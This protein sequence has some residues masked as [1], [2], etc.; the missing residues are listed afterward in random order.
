MTEDELKRLKELPVP[1]PAAGAR[2][3]AVAAALAAFEPALSPDIGAPQ[4]SAALPR[5]RDTSSISEGSSKMRYRRPAAIAASIVALAVAVPLFMTHLVRTPTGPDRVAPH[6][7]L[8]AL[9]DPGAAHPP[10]PPPPADMERTASAASTP[11][12]P[13]VD[14][15]PEEKSTACPPQTLCMR[16]TG[17]VEQIK[18]KAA[19]VLAK[20]KAPAAA[21]DAPTARGV[22]TPPATS[23]D[24]IAPSGAIPADQGEACPPGRTCTRLPDEDARSLVF[25]D[26]LLFDINKL[27]G[28]DRYEPGTR[29]SMAQEYKR[30]EERQ[31]AELQ[32]KT[33]PASPATS[34]APPVKRQSGF[35]VPSYDFTFRPTYYAERGVLWGG[36]FRHRLET[37][38]YSIDIADIDDE[39]NPNAAVDSRLG[40]WRG[41][42]R[43]KGQ[44]NLDA[45][46]KYGWDITLESG[47]GQA[48]YDTSADQ[49]I[50][51]VNA[52]KFQRDECFV[53]TQSYIDT[54]V[55]N[56]ALDLREDRSLMLRYE[57]KRSC[58]YG[59]GT[60]ALSQVFYDIH[61][62]NAPTSGGHVATS[63]GIPTERVGACPPGKACTDHTRLMVAADWQRKVVDPID[64]VWTPF[65]DVR[66]DVYS[67]SD[68]TSA[69]PAPPTTSAQDYG[70][71]LPDVFK[72]TVP[73]NGASPSSKN[74]MFGP[75]PKIDRAQPLYLQTD[76]L[77]Y[78]E[79]NNRV[80][81]EGN[82]EI[83]YNNY[84]LAADKVIYDP[85][86]NKLTAEGNAQLK[87][88]N[89][90]I[91][92]ADRFEAT[93]DFRDA[94]IQALSV[95]TQDDTRVASRTAIRKESN[96]TELQNGK[97]T[98]CRNEPG[99][100]PLWCIRANRIIRDQQA[101]GRTT[102]TAD[103]DR[104]G[105]AAPHVAAR[106]SAPTVIAL[107]PTQTVV[108]NAPSTSSRPPAAAPPAPEQRVQACP[109]G[110][111]CTLL[112]PKS[113]ALEQAAAPSKPQ[114][115]PLENQVAAQAIRGFTVGGFRA[116]E[117]EPAQGLRFG[118][119]TPFP[120]DGRLDTL[121]SYFGD[122]P[123]PT[124]DGRDR[125][126]SAAANPVKS[127]ASEPVST[128]SIDVDSASYSFVR[129]ALNAA[130]LPPKEA[131]RVEE[132][133]N[134]FPYDYP[135][136]EDRSAPFRP[137]V[138]V[139]PSPWNPT[140]K[141][142]HIAIKG[143]DVP[144][145]ERPRAN[146]VLLID[147]SGSMAPEDRLP[148]IKNA[149]RM[150]IDTLRPDDTVGIVTYAGQTQVALEPTK[151]A[152]KRKILDVIE[153]LH[154]GGSTAGGAGIQEAYRM[155]EGAFDKTAVNRVVLATDGDFNV[156]TT[157]VDELKS[158]VERKRETGVYLSVL[159]V[160][161]G[162]YN[163]ALM[164]A[165]AQNGN[166]V[167][168]YID[169]LNEARKV[170]VEEA[171]SSLFPIAKDVK[172]QIEL[173]PG[174]VTEYRLIG[175][176]TRLLRREDFNNDKIDAGDIGS[177]HMVTAIYE[178]TPV[179]SPKL[180]EDLRYRQPVAA[181]PKDD[182][183]EYGFLRIN[184]KL[185]AESVSR[186]I[187]LP[188]TQALEK[189]AIDQ[190]PAD[191]RFS[192]A[193]AAFGQL[194]KGEPYL[195]GFG[196]D[197]VI[198]LAAPAR[199]EDLF[200]YRAEL[201][202]LVRLAKTAQP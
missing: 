128:F 179:G 119:S 39:L 167:A 140:N 187:E 125:F 101:A 53:L 28:Y 99:Q 137:T 51:D 164:Q 9:P 10:A 162:N 23:G 141:L 157:S 186:R 127:V 25:D 171:S 72:N 19:E 17:Q 195:K 74:S 200:G 199:G 20:R 55:E 161:R 124:Q 26:T 114:A 15:A 148:L 48:P 182:K 47:N 50:Q 178:V 40:N 54:F 147:T 151:V 175:Y 1:A 86:L 123:P 91:T 75:K 70:V 121:N 5:L 69:P 49:R 59:Y 194:L 60:D 21:E 136:P 100:P 120:A 145:S 158:L 18:Q 43:A 65:A 154:A 193:V 12:A 92:R 38:R 196:Y 102:P 183:G 184:Y 98:P 7:K 79:K 135:L 138:T 94:F 191:V 190:A 14:T 63:G 13:S 71:R 143:Y 56:A 44:F 170:L 165:L 103:L 188:I 87:D 173:N 197:E 85:S 111:T 142:V 27:S 113:R 153:R 35:L 176:E 198:A 155:A 169:T 174:M 76:R 58:Q 115:V 81:A 132:M 41:S 8:A 130:R 84:I 131:V 107:A 168:A 68:T 185:P 62:E 34:A 93:D 105:D 108:S 6:D 201:L 139:L 110:R 24:R 156:G 77:V 129:R 67:F 104:K 150:L 31:V 202:N 83:Y 90:S 117:R 33:L 112:H 64:Q 80:I 149:F 78:D 126:A 134:Y 42:L 22:P 37:G 3:R 30:Q 73:G 189:A 11:P 152:D 97:F 82:V 95:V 89:G 57:L 146:L 180:V 116:S 61:R 159:G 66:G 46:W 109:P 177:G 52:L 36:E 118:A 181:T 144:K 4:G 172:I 32:T 29:A 160:G 192:V 16:L 2:E 106:D 45:W 133:I 122:V 166:G 163:D 88:P 96:V